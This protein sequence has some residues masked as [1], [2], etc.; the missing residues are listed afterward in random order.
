[1]TDSRML[2]AVLVVVGVIGFV[3]LA[4]TNHADSGVY[5]L[6][7]IPALALV[8]VG[9]KVDQVRDDQALRHLDNTQRLDTLTT[10]MVEVKS[11]V[12]ALHNGALVPPIREAMTLALGDYLTTSS[13]VEHPYRDPRFGGAGDP[14]PLSGDAT[15]AT[16]A[17]AEETAAKSRP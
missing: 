14:A 10:D 11:A 6:A 2:P 17:A 13:I 12:A 9:G 3:V 15:A 1:M 8:I 7:A 16:L 4:A 5:L